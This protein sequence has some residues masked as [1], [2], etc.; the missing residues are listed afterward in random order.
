M[1]AFA[2]GSE[3]LLDTDLKIIL[4]DLKNNECCKTFW[5]FSN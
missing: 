2:D 1:N 5:Y 4:L 3:I